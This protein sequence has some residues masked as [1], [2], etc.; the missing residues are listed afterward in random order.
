MPRPGGCVMGIDIAFGPADGRCR[1]HNVRRLRRV[2]TDRGALHAGCAVGDG[3]AAGSLVNVAFGPGGSMETAV[4]GQAQ[5]TIEL[6]AVHGAAITAGMKST[7]RVA[8]GMI[9]AVVST[10]VVASA[11]VTAGMVAAAFETARMVAPF[12]RTASVISAPFETA[13]VVSAAAKAVG[14]ESAAAKAISMVSTAFKA[15]GM[16]PATAE[17]AATKAAAAKAAEAAG[18]NWRLGASTDAEHDEKRC[19]NEPVHEITSYFFSEM[20]SSTTSGVSGKEAPPALRAT[21]RQPSTL[22][23]PGTRISRSRDAV[24]VPSGRRRTIRSASLRAWRSRVP[25]HVRRRHR[26]TTSG[27]ARPWDPSR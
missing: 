16:E 12:G 1:W 8:A 10:G 4:S 18:R 2:G 20:R 7:F 26:T 11:V 17:P 15:A 14:V 21:D 19:R 5:E 22:S 9:A 6:A 27:S 23:S 3:R 25:C 13:A 24:G